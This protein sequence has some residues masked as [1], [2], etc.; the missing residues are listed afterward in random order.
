MIL[1]AIY[2]IYFIFMQDLHK[3]IL[4]SYSLTPPIVSPVTKYLC[5]N[6]YRQM[7]GSM[8]AIVAADRTVTG[9]TA[10]ELAPAAEAF[11]ALPLCCITEDSNFISSYCRV[12]Y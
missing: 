12:V 1:S 8:V 9:V 5:K 6:G 11:A 3:H 4:F 2:F 7:I 10:A